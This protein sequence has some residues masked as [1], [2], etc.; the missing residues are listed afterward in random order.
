MQKVQKTVGVPRVELVGEIAQVP[1]Q[2]RL[3]EPHMQKI[4]ETALVS[5]FEFVEELA[6]VPVQKR[7]PVPCQKAQKNVQGPLVE[8][9]D[10]IPGARAGAGA[11][12][13]HAEGPQN[14]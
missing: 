13:P 8:K 12:A 5:Q 2:E 10:E 1:V 14:R 3:Q 6:E 9:V 11:G 7:V 4:R